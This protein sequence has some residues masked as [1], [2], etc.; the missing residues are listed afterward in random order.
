MQ[1]HSNDTYND[2]EAARR[3]DDFKKRN[4]CHRRQRSSV[5]AVQ[6]FGTSLSHVPPRLISWVVEPCA[7]A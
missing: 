3:R 2:E 7:C 6:N 5:S 4:P 1:Q